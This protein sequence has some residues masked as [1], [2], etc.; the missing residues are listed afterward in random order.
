VQ[1]E[2]CPWAALH[3]QRVCHLA[4][5]EHCFRRAIVHPA[6]QV[7]VAPYR[8]KQRVWVMQPLFDPRRIFA[9]GPDAVERAR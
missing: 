8:H 5:D 6:H 7:A 1:A 2:K 3:A 9:P 4:G